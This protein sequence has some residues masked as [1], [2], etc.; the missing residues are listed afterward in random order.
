[1]PASFAHDASRD[2]T[3]AANAWL[4]SLS[5]PQRAKAKFDLTGE[6]RE[7]WHF[8]PRDR[9]GLSIKE[10]SAE[11][12]TLAHALLTI[13]LS[14]T[15]YAKATNIMSLESVL[16]VIEN[17]P[18]HRDPEKY[19]FSI[20]GTPA[21]DKPWG[22]RVEGHHLSFN[23][24][25]PGNDHAPSVTPSFM[26]TNPGVVPDGPRKGVR[27]LENEEELAR[28]LV[29][30]L[31]KAQLKTALIMEKAPDDVLNVPGRNHSE[32]AGITWSDLDKDQQQALLDIVREYLYRY[33]T[34]IADSEMKRVEDHGLENLHFAWAGPLEEGAPHYYR[35]Q[36]GNFVL[37]Y[38]NTQNGANHAHS[39]WR[40][41]DRDF[42]LDE[43]A[44][45]YR[46]HA[47]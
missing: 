12:R 43:L 22:W 20:F 10:M 1:M 42:G 35:I 30:S 40:D 41:F 44:E 17:R 38:D 26:G 15:G 6:E 7:N 29:K 27:V 19:Y 23:F 32:P 14:E 11:Q 31:S 45:H 34:D 39:L 24:T 5:D 9:N 21:A 16:A 4:G 36:G 25:I 13:S 33:R 8:I 28:S 37:E 18:E 47:H 2:M 3:G 46:Q